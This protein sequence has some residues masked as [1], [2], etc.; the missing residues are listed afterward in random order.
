LR[1]DFGPVWLVFGSSWQMLLMVQQHRRYGHSL[2]QYV[3]DLSGATK[4][5]PG[6]TSVSETG[7]SSRA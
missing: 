6:A 7:R 4:R 2:D 1:G 5:H 3:H